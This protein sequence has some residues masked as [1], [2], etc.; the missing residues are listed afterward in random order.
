MTND[1]GDDDLSPEEARE[2]LDHELR[3]V[4][5]RAAYQAL[6]EVCQDTKAP[7]P[8]RATS[9][10]ALLRA[11]GYF[12]RENDR[13]EKPIHELSM[14]EIER[15]IQKLNRQSAEPKRRRRRSTE[16]SVFD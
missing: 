4:G 7:A 10:T 1:F 6:L 9:G 12:N 3:T 13:D 14:D 11:A 8:A 15:R 5:A 2:A 16:P